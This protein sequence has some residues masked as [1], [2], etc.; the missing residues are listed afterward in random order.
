MSYPARTA[1][2]CSSILAR[3]RSVILR[4]TVLMAFTWSKDWMCRLTIRLLSISRK[5]ASIR[6][7]SSGAK[8]WTK[9]TAPHLRPMRKSLPV[10]NSNEVGAMKSFVERPEGASQSQE[11][12]NGACSSMWNTSCSWR[13]RSMPVSG[14][15]LT[16]RRLKLFRMSVSIRSSRGFAVFR[17]SASMPKVRYLVFTSPLLPFASWPCSIPVYSCR[18]LSKSSPWGGMSMLRAKTSS[19]AARFRKESWNRM[20]LSK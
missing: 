18:M 19:D 11:K 15:A 10:R 16:P 3:S 9:E 12:R 6:S 20:E 5:S 7:F 17:F 13:R 2:F 8:I 1:F 4:F 14:S